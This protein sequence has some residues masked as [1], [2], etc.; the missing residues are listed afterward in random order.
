M[1]KNLRQIATM[2]LTGSSPP[3]R[4]SVPATI[5]SPPPVPSAFTESPRRT[6][7]VPEVEHI[8]VIGSLQGFLVVHVNSFAGDPPQFL[9]TPF[10]DKIDAY[11]GAEAE[12]QARKIPFIPRGE[13]A[14]DSMPVAHIDL[15][16]EG[17]PGALG[18]PVTLDTQSSYPYRLIDDDLPEDS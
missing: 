12:A 2:G 1:R 7:S 18:D 14:P 9:G 11:A 6:A 5:P 4:E 10:K 3:P 17:K 16:E 13:K 15:A 8:T